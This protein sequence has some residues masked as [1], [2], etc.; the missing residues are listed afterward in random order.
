M[1][2]DS[3]TLTYTFEK[4]FSFWKLILSYCML[5]TPIVEKWSISVST[6]CIQNKDEEISAQ[7]IES[8]KVV[9]LDVEIHFLQK[10][11]IYFCR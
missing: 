11:I 9:I 6:K 3:L 5:N 1:Y 2:N 8:V 4:M 7:S 10:C